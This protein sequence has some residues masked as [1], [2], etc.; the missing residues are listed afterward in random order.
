M[1]HVYSVIGRNRQL[2]KPAGCRGLTS[3]LCSMEKLLIALIHIRI[4]YPNKRSISIARE[5]PK[6][7]LCAAGSVNDVQCGSL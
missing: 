1:Q 3:D 7:Q 4:S 2:N 6:I 5:Q